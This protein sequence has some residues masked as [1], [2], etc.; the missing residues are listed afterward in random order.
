[1]RNS[2][3]DCLFFFFYCLDKSITI[4]SMLFSNC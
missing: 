3:F 4:L 1:M 2:G